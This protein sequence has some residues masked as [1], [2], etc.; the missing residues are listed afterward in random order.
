MGS[1]RPR[2][3]DTPLAREHEDATSSSAR[4]STLDENVHAI[5]RWEN[6]ILLARSNSEVTIVPRRNKRR[7]SPMILEAPPGL[8]RMEVLQT[9]PRCE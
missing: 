1:P 7:D 8:N 5:K 4:A 3:R 6:A 2:R 9:V